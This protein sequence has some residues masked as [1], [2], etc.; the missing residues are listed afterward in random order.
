MAHWGR[1]HRHTGIPARRAASTSMSWTWSDGPGTVEGGHLQHRLGADGQA[2]AGSLA[3][4]VAGDAHVPQH[5]EVGVG[6]GRIAAE[7]HVDP[8]REHVGDRSRTPGCGGVVGRI[9][10]HRSPGGGQEFVVVVTGHGA[11]GQHGAGSEQAVA[12]GE[13]DVAA[14]SEAA[15]E[16][17]VRGQLG[18]M[19]GDAHGA[20][21]GQF[22]HF[23]VE[24]QIARRFGRAAAEPHLE[25]PAP[26][27]LPTV[28]GVQCL[29]DGGL[30]GLPH[31]VVPAQLVAGLGTHGHHDLAE[32][33]PDARADARLGDPVE[34]VALGQQALDERGR[35]RLDHL[36]HGQAGAGR[37]VGL[38]VGA[39]Q[40][41]DSPEQ[42]VREV[43]Q[44][45][46][47][48]DAPQ[49]RLG[50]MHV[51][52]DQPRQHDVA[53]EVDLLGTGVTALQ[54]RGLAH[55]LDAVAGDHQSAVVDDLPGRVHRD[56]RP[57]GEDRGRHRRH[58]NCPE[59]G[60]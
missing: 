17:V 18:Q 2:G 52:V 1:G 21:A 10:R 23:V 6:G 47:F 4:G 12:T 26:G 50:Q 22:R 13:L 8:G 9:V 34:S 45:P 24:G 39:L 3:G 56:D 5:V 38:G 25:P 59:F 28:V 29:G 54:F 43:R 20:L 46:P 51:G 58:R 57:V 49:H 44:P 53:G 11:V 27:T 32:G 48:R 36:Q 40:R 7:G 19:D 30:P 55:G 37:G 42:P 35:A 33:G 41:E 14:E 60:R 15:G 16:L 31:S